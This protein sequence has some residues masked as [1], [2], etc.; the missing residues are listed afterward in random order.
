MAKYTENVHC[1]G[2]VY[3]EWH[4]VPSRRRAAATTAR[5]RGFILAPDASSAHGTLPLC[6]PSRPGRQH[7]ALPPHESE[8]ST[9]LRQVQARG[10]P[11]PGSNVGGIRPRRRS[12]RTVPRSQADPYPA[13]CAPRLVR[14]FVSLGS[15]SPQCPLR[16]PAGWKAGARG[17]APWPGSASP[18]AAGP[19][20]SRAFFPG[21]GGG[22]V[23]AGDGLMATRGAAGGVTGGLGGA[24]KAT[25][26][27]KARPPALRGERWLGGVRSL[28]LLLA[29]HQRSH[30]WTGE[31]VTAGFDHSFLCGVVLLLSSS[32][33]KS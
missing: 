12:R 31:A 29:C 21:A 20:A 2:Q 17:E 8:R 27:S 32:S 10:A 14:R 6:R 25:A 22:E 23:S 13:A 18:A 4:R 9:R 3:R 16:T 11:S 5:P 30:R 26:S 28:F 19:R 15:S 7:S 33:L 1:H 24:G